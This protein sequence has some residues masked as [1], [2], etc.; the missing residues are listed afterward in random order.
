[1]LGKNLNFTK[2]FWQNIAKF[3]HAF[4]ESYSLNTITFKILYVF[5]YMQNCAAKLF[6]YVVLYM[7]LYSIFSPLILFSVNIIIIIITSN[8][9]KNN[10]D[11]IIVL[12]IILNSWPDLL[13]SQENYFIIC[14][15]HSY[16]RFPVSNIELFFLTLVVV[17]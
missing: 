10:N 4:R 14:S 5:L 17:I 16:T 8:N 7:Y 3:Y 15:N 9:N 13:G 1:M 2:T 11:I 12:I 6:S